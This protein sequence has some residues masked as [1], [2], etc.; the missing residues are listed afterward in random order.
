MFFMTT[1]E[2]SP[3]CKVSMF[4][5]GQQ[6]KGNPLSQ[7]ATCGLLSLVQPHRHRVH[8]PRWTEAHQLDSVRGLVSVSWRLHEWRDTKRN[9]SRHTNTKNP[10]KHPSPKWHSVSEQSHTH[11]R[12]FS[13]NNIM[14]MNNPLV[15]TSAGYTIL[16]SIQ[17]VKMSTQ[18]TEGQ[19]EKQI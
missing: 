5:V 8:V 14:N 16:C 1:C 10:H 7:S 19:T 3:H 17:A 2:M 11:F 15:L 13:S 9:P 6:T 4:L 18:E 12:S